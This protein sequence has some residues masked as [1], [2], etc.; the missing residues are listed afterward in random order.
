VNPERKPRRQ[1]DRLAALA[2]TFAEPGQAPPERP[3]PAVRPTARTRPFRRTLDLL[4]ARHHD[5][6]RRQ[7]E[8]A[9]QLGQPHVSGQYLLEELVALYLT[10]EVVA[11]RLEERLRK[12]YEELDKKPGR[13]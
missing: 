7:Q 4:P 1:S 8:L 2:A 5:L 12:K 11:R 9:V 6:H 13:K 10:D 3:E